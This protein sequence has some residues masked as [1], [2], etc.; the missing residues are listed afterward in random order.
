MCNS[1]GVAN[2]HATV[3]ENDDLTVRDLDWLIQTSINIASNDFLVL[4]SP[5]G[6]E[7]KFPVT[8][9]LYTLQI[10]RK[11]LALEENDEPEED[12]F[13]NLI[14][15]NTSLPSTVIKCPDDAR[16]PTPLLD[17]VAVRH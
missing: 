17:E 3:D 10:G 15:A 13:I 9:G 8:P 11:T 16:L 5:D 2:I 7:M 1:Y 14:T 6:N 4:T 12:V